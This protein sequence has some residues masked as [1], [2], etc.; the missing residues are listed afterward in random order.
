VGNY[1]VVYADNGNQTG[2][3]SAQVMRVNGSVVELMIKKN[4]Y[5]YTATLDTTKT[6]GKLPITHV[7]TMDVANM[8]LNGKIVD[9]TE[10]LHQGFEYRDGKIFVPISRS[11]SRHEFWFGNLPKIQTVA[12]GAKT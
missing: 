11:N 6:S 2:A 8:W 10:W 7:F 1:T 4:K 5:L 12:A 9:T 3:S